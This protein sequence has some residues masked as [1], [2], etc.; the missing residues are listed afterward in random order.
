MKWLSEMDIAS[1]VSKLDKIG[2]PDEY[3]TLVDQ[4]VTMFKAQV[5]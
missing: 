1:V 4:F 3:M 5:H 2:L